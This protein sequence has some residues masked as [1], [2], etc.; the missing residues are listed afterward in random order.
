MKFFHWIVW[1]GGYVAGMLLDTVF[2]PVFFNAGGFF[3]ELPVLLFG[4]LLQPAWFSFLYVMGA[5]I[6]RDIVAP[7]LVPSYTLFFLFLFLVVRGFSA[8]APWD[9]P[10]RRIAS[11]AVG[12]L[13][14]PFVWAASALVTRI[15]FHPANP[16]GFAP[17]IAPSFA[18]GEVLFV[19]LWFCIFSWLAVKRFRKTRADELGRIA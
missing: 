8:F 6:L 4:V 16:A 17:R 10:L 7:P 13:S 19:G 12:L 9:E 15:L 2:L 5:G 18:A 14:T 11:V 3:F 1:V